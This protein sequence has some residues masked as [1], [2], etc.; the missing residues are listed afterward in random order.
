MIAVCV[1]GVNFWAT[2]CAAK[3]KTV[4][5][6]TVKA[7]LHNPDPPLKPGHVSKARAK[8]KLSIPTVKIWIMA[9]ITGS[10]FA[11]KCSIASI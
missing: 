5:K 4:Q 11:A 8:G 6:S 7:M 1:D 9:R 3:A 2:F 10:V